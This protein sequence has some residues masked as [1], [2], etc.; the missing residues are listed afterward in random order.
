MKTALLLLL[1]SLPVFSAET[2][3]IVYCWSDS[4]QTY[5]Q[6]GQFQ[7]L[8]DAERKAERLGQD[9]YIEEEDVP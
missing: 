3:Y 2:N 8:D 7:T 1:I 4:T 9:C 6:E 5:V